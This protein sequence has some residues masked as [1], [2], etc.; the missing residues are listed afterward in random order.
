MYWV[1]NGYVYTLYQSLRHYLLCEDGKSCR[2]A[3]I[4]DMYPHSKE[5]D[6]DFNYLSD[7]K[8]DEIFDSTEYKKVVRYKPLYIPKVKAFV[9][10]QY[11]DFKLPDQH[12]LNLILDE[13]KDILLECFSIGFTQGARDP[14]EAYFFME[15][16][17]LNPHIHPPGVD[18][19][20]KVILLREAFL[21]FLPTT[22]PDFQNLKTVDEFCELA[23]SY[24]G[25]A[26][27]TGRLKYI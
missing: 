1:E 2:L 17:L 9:E 14:I 26:Q 19:S 6:I 5:W 3:T 10:F 21:V 25:H 8:L 18:N 16:F 15:D 13:E 23:K 22:A 11:Q 7:E 20:H 27:R 12:W 4:N 24:K